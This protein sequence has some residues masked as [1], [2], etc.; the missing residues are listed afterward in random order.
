MRNLSERAAYLQGL[1]EGLDLS[2]ESKEGK[3]LNGM[4]D[5]MQDLAESVT[6][7]R[8]AHHEL[9][10]YVETLDEDLYDLEDEV[11]EGIPEMV[12]GD[13]D[14][15]DGYVDVEC[16]NCKETVS[17]DADILD[18]DDV[19]EVTCPNCDTVVFVN[20]DE[21]IDMERTTEDI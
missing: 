11:Y 16:P 1:A 9:E 10:D 21:A 3:V 7:L 8:S 17:F 2:K 14:T 13:S 12:M 6:T 4:I 20:D 18:D 19:I 5:L 15:E